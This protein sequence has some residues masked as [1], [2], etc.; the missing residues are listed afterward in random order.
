MPSLLVLFSDCFDLWKL[1]RLLVNG[2]RFL[3]LGLKP[4]GFMARF[5][6]QNPPPLPRFFLA[7][8]YTL[9]YSNL[10][11]QNIRQV[12]KLPEGSGLVAPT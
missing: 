2:T 8:A 5:D 4:Q 6:K 3:S 12:P 10:D 7:P 9:C 11:I 1:C